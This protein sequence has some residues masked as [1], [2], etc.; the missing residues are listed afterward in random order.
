MSYVS[1]WDDEPIKG[2]QKYLTATAQNL[3]GLD[4]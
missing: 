3:C 1:G 2:H 4:H